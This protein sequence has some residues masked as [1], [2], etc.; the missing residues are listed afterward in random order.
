MCRYK[1]IDTNALPRL[2]GGEDFVRRLRFFALP[3]QF[4]HGSE[5]AAGAFWWGDLGE[6]TRNLTI[7]GK[8]FEFWEWKVSEAVVPPHKLSLVIGHG[9]MTVV[10]CVGLQMRIEYQ[11]IHPRGVVGSLGYLRR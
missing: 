7:Y 9:E 11:G 6:T 1:L 2:G 10:A 4:C 5:Q 8:K 3:W